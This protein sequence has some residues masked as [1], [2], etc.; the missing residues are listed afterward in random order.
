MLNSC[1]KSIPN[2]KHSA[3]LGFL[4]HKEESGGIHASS[5]C[6]NGTFIWS[7]LWKHWVPALYPDF[8]KPPSSVLPSL[9][10][11]ASPSGHRGKMMLS[12][13]HSPSLPVS[14]P[15]CSL[16]LKCLPSGGALIFHLESGWDLSLS[17]QNT[18]EVMQLCPFQP[19]FQEALEFL[20]PLLKPC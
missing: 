7:V 3:V 9:P 18:A 19:S 12:P 5:L 6:W 11:G 10:V 20:F 2:S 8:P 14:T 4:Y 13:L 17:G 15:P 1:E 16:T